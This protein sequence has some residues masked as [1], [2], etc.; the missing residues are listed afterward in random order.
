[1]KIKFFTFCFVILLFAFCTFSFSKVDAQSV[2]YPIGELGNCRDSKE[3]YLYCEVPDNKPACWAYQTYVVEG[4][5]LSESTQS[6]IFPIVDLGN[7]AN[8]AECKAFCEKIENRDACMSFAKVHSLGQYKK[9]QEILQR[10]QQE[11]GCTTQE[12]CKLF[13]SQP[14]NKEKCLNFA[15]SLQPQNTPQHKEEL[16]IKAKELLGCQSIAECRAMC[17]DPINHDKCQQLIASGSAKMRPVMKAR[18]TC[19]TQSECYKICQEHP[20]QCPSFKKAQDQPKEATHPAFQL[21]RPSVF[22]PTSQP[23]PETPQ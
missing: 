5:V 4:Q 19:N 20:D 17:E 16:L 8:A 23:I 13:C 10:A 18:L 7:C 6:M 12:A 21:P 22:P 3:C 1:M 11:L 9:Q 15:N 14:E 2:R